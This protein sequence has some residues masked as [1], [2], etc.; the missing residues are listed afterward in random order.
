MTK[1]EIEQAA[2]EWVNGDGR[3]VPSH[4]SIQPA[5]IAGVK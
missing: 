3:N 2:Y 5:F 4:Y 1:E